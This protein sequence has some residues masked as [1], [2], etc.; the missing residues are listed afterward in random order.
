EE[1]AIATGLSL[2]EIYQK[3]GIPE[4]VSKNT[5]MKEISNVVPSYSFDAAKEKAGK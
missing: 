3:L 5:K 2:K 1:A 4:N